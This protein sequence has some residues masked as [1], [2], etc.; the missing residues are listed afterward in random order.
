MRLEPPQYSLIFHVPAEGVDDQE[1]DDAMKMHPDGKGIDVGRCPKECVT[2]IAP[3]E[4]VIW[5]F[6]QVMLRSF[7]TV[8]DRDENRI[9]LALAKGIRDE[10]G[11]VR[12]LIA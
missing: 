3:D 6:G 8:F 2:G 11:N 12:E 10:D 9:G 5:T 7:Y 4:D 1:C